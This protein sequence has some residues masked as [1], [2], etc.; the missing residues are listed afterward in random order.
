M[1]KEQ[2]MAKKKKKQQICLFPGCDKPAI[3]RGLSA[4][5]YNIALRQV[6][7]GKVTWAELEAQGKALPPA[8]GCI[9]KN[10]PAQEWFSVESNKKSTPVVQEEPKFMMVKNEDTVDA[11]ANVHLNMMYDEHNRLLRSQLA[12]LTKLYTDTH[13]IAKDIQES[14]ESVSMRHNSIKNETEVTEV[15]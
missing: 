1:R 2:Y 4:N 7:A 10:T 6:K 9:K 11:E 15:G 12:R 14:I 3:A 8:G 13:S 5:Y